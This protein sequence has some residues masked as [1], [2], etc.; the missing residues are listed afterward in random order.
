MADRHRSTVDVRQR[1][2]GASLSEPGA[3]HRGKRLVDLEGA[4]VIDAQTG[5]LEH[6]GRGWNRAGQHHHRVGPD[7]GTGVEAHDR[8]ETKFGGL[9]RSG[10]E[11]G[12]RTVRDLRC[13]ASGNDATLL[14]GGR[15][16]RELVNVGSGPNALVVDEVPD[17]DYLVAEEASC[18]CGGGAIV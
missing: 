7:D 10:H 14:E 6:L 16:S 11:Q 18:G 9:L 8:G 17:S 5:T 15:Q 2:I 12:G 13:V 4:D 1:R 3:D